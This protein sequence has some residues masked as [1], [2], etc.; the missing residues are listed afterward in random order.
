[1]VTVRIKAVADNIIKEFKINIYE[2]IQGVLVSSP[3][4]VI[5]DKTL[6]SQ[7]KYYLKMLMEIRLNCQLL[8]LHDG[9]LTG[10]AFVTSDV[11]VS[12]NSATY[13]VTPVNPGTIKLQAVA[14]LNSSEDSY[15][16]DVITVLK[17][18][19]NIN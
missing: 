8:L 17:A 6:K 1:M 5:L 10:S 14:T 4:V 7:V 15:T 11:T 2:N 12:R 19:E 3:N 18:I 13:T 16:T 9:S